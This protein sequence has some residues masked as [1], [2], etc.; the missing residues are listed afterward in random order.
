MSQHHCE[1]PPWLSPKDVLAWQTDRTELNSA[2]KE[3]DERSFDELESHLAYGYGAARYF[4]PQPWDATL[5]QQLRILWPGDWE[6]D[7]I[8][9]RLGWDWRRT[10]T[11]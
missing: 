5:E 7:Q 2:W 8:Y 9:I 11:H 4:D 6:V 3:R 1:A 10:E